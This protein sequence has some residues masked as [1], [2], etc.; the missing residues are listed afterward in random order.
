MKKVL[1]LA[2]VLTVANL[3]TSSADAVIRT[4]ELLDVLPDGN[5]VAV[6]DLQKIT[7]SGFW[8]NLSAQEKFKSSIDKAHG[9]L[10]DLGL[11]LSDLSS[12]ALVVPSGSLNGAVVAVTGRFEQH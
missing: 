7:A 9:E 10:A 1:L 2:F 5:V 4:D 3:R 6:V 11:T 8:A 12:L